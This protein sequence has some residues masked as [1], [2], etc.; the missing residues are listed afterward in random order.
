MTKDQGGLNLSGLS[1]GELNRMRLEFAED[2]R[3]IQ[4]ELGRLAEA[5]A[6]LKRDEMQRSVDERLQ[7]SRIFRAV[8]RGPSGS[9]GVFLLS[10]ELEG[11]RQ[12]P[13]SP[14]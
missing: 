3:D 11:E 14:E 7:T 2:I 8:I 13:S 4:R 1:H 5:Y 12:S 10:T 6:A 9:D